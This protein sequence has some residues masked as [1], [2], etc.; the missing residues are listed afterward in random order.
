MQGKAEL[1]LLTSNK[2]HDHFIYNISVAPINPGE[3]LGQTLPHTTS[4]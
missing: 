2:T 4:T 1:R 3:P